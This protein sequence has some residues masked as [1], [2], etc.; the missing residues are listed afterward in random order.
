MLWFL[1]FKVR[2]CSKMWQWHV[3]HSCFNNT[4][5]FSGENIIRKY[6]PDLLTQVGFGIPTELALTTLW[7]VQGYDCVPWKRNSILHLSIYIKCKNLNEEKMDNLYETWW[8]PPQH[9]PQ[10]QLPHG[11]ALQGTPPQGRSH[12]VCRSQCDRSL[13]QRPEI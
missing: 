11:P 2:A 3:K 5:L 7:D 12:W 6:L 4:K 13:W 8:P 1:H 10:F 9:S